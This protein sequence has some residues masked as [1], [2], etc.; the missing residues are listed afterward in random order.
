[1]RGLALYQKTRQ[2]RD[3]SRSVERIRNP[4]G[5][6]ELRYKVKKYIETT[7]PYVIISAGLGENQTTA[8]I[9]MG[10]RRRA[11]RRSS[12]MWS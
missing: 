10:T 9:R 12:P 6:T 5:E 11:T 8:F 2:I 3:A 7:Y 1:M 4:T